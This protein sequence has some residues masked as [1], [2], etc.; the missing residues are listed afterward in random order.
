MYLA[1]RGLISALVRWNGWLLNGGI[2]VPSIQYTFRRYEKKYLL[3]PDQYR[4]MQKALSQY[5]EPDEYGLHTI[6]NIYFDTPDFLMTRNSLSRPKYKEKFRLRSYG[7]TGQDSPVYAEIKKK[8]K[9]I[10]YKRRICV[11]H[12]DLYRFFGGEM[13]QNADMQTQLE[14]QWLL[15]HWQPFPQ[16]YIGYDRIAYLGREDENLRI[17]FDQNLRWRTHDLYLCG[18]DA[19]EPV[20]DENKIIMEIKFPQSSPLWLASMLSE[21]GIFP[22]SCSKIGNCYTRHL[23]RIPLY[24][25][26]DERMELSC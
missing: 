13:L 11:P 2:R 1:L 7:I 26:D 12:R 19:G 20:W 10:V 18:G 5:V 22:V 25:P 24:L 16:V 3:T 9:H 6:N 4:D 15:Y 14:I 21:H 8:Y 23:A 17:T